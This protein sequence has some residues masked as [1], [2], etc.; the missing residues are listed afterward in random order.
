MVSAIIPAILLVAAVAAEARMG[1]N[2][3]ATLRQLQREVADLKML[4]KQK[5]AAPCS[6]SWMICAA[7]GTPGAGECGP[8]TDFT[9]NAAEDASLI[10]PSYTNDIKL[11]DGFVFPGFEPKEDN[12]EG[13]GEGEGETEAPPKPFIT[14]ESTCVNIDAAANGQIP[15]EAPCIKDCIDPLKK[16]C[17]C[18]VRVMSKKLPPPAPKE[19]SADGDTPSD[20]DA[21]ADGAAPEGGSD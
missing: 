20:G 3:E 15:K 21:K 17:P 8:S 14:C 9:T 1:H 4:E 6:Q 13:E 16:E 2:L 11:Q 5:D 12:G 18:C 7:E 10:D 19:D